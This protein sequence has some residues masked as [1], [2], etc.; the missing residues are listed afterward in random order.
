MTF[1]EIK[2]RITKRLDD[3]P[4]T[5][6]TYTAAEVSAAVNEGL[7]LFALLTLCLERTASL[8]ISA[9][10][11]F[12]HLLPVLSDYLVPLRLVIGGVKVKPATLAQL[13][14]LDPNWRAAVGTTKRYIAKGFDVMGFYPRSTATAAITYARSAAALVN[15]AD[16]P[17]I[18]ELYHPLLIDFGAYRVLA[19]QGGQMLARALGY[20]SPYLDGAA[21]LAGLVRARALALRYDTLP[22]ELERKDL[23]RLTSIRKDLLPARKEQ[24]AWQTPQA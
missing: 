13:D 4:T 8:G 24:P 10:A 14:A 2:G 12:Y 5:P 6:A 9:T 19:P 3:D 1:G 17:E 20:L 15:D 21:R 23:S 7:Q 22:P 18:P 11:G 16:V